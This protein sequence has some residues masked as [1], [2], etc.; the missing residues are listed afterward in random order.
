MVTHHLPSVLICLHCHETWFYFLYGEC[1]I[2]GVPRRNTVRVRT[3]WSPPVTQELVRYRQVNVRRI[4]AWYLLGSLHTVYETL[5]HKS[6][7]KFPLGDLHKWL[8]L[9]MHSWSKLQEGCL[10]CENDYDML[11]LCNGKQTVFQAAGWVLEMLYLFSPYW[12]LSFRQDCQC[13]D[14]ENNWDPA[15]SKHWHHV[16][17]F[18]SRANSCILFYFC[19]RGP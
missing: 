10:N 9:V 7:L 1:I 2:D 3:V 15:V 13:G 8:K 14:L 12:L 19:K 6:C 18:V 11:K 5:I 17:S 4:P 16:A